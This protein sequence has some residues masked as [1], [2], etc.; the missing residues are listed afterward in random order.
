MV[1]ANSAATA[2]LKPVSWARR[3]FIACRSQSFDPL[4]LRVPPG[5]EHQHPLQRQSDPVPYACA[6]RRAEDWYVV[7]R[8]VDVGREDGDQQQDDAPGGDPAQRRDED[9]AAEA[10]LGEAGDEDQPG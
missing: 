1:N 8:D 5:P 9:G 3:R 4:S 7:Q 10:D 6:L 2:E